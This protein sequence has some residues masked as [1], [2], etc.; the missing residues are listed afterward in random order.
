MKIT[1]LTTVEHPVVFETGAPNPVAP[2]ND[3]AKASFALHSHVIEEMGMTREIWKIPEGAE[4][5]LPEVSAKKL[6]DLGFA[7]AA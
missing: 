6:V 7:A 4:I 5:D 2:I 3:I 1:L